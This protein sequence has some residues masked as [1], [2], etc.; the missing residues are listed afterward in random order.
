MAMTLKIVVPPHPLIGHWLTML[1]CEHTPAA[2][3]ETGLEEIGRW[4]SYEASRD[5]L[6]HREEIVKTCNAETKGIVIESNVPLMAL[7]VLPSGLS[8]WQGGRKVLPNASLCLGKLPEQ[9]GQQTGVIIFIDQI[10]SGKRLH[11]FLEILKNQGVSASR[12]R[13]ICAL[14]SSPGL[15][16]L[17]EVMPELTIHTA[18]IDPDLLEDGQISPGIGNPISRLQTRI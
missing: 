2:L 7:A 9:I 3:Y 18:C 15:K 4:L 1:R 17:G 14:A 6:P 12:I 5:W 16:K 13:I 11:G 8:L 10:A